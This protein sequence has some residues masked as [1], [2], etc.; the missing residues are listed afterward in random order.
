MPR[1][2][3]LAPAIVWAVFALSATACGS[4]EAGGVRV[5]TTDS[6]GVV[7][8]RNLSPD[9]PLAFTSEAVRSLGGKETEE[10]SFYR[11]GSWNVGTDASGNIY[12]L[13]REAHRV[14]AF[15]SA[16]HHLWTRGRQGGGPGE[17]QHPFALAVAG[18]GRLWV[19]DIGKRS[20]VH[21]DPTGELLPS[22]LVPQGYYGGEAKWTSAGM[23]MPLQDPASGADRL[24]LLTGD[25]QQVVLSSIP[26]TD[27]KPIHFESCGMTFSGMPPI[28][29]P[30]LVWTASARAVVV[31]RSPE[32]MLD[33]YEDGRLVRSVRRDV[34]PRPATA[35]LARA[36]LGD[37][38]R[39]GTPM[40]ERVCDPEEAVEQRGFAP[41]LPTVGRIALAPTGLLWVERYDVGDEPKPIDVFDREGRYL[42]TLPAGSPFPIAFLPDGRILVA[43]KDELDV[44]RL[45]VKTASFP[46]W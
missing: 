8:V 42:G 7:I 46:E 39:V 37:G 17:L 23:V 24:V 3:P 4:G 16:G 2:H 44:E 28:F 29:S 11:V 15:D 1:S 6:A 35:E 41:H 38:M 10:E 13:D 40:G 36:S 12:V 9:R 45:V 14:H 43:E 19:V 32:Y 25:S 33:V 34:P 31:A 22:E 30:S 18:D 20:L 21:W 27:R 26:A 5:E